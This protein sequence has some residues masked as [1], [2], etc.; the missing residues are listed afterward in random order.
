MRRYN[1]HFVDIIP[2]LPSEVINNLL[3]LGKNGVL[4][5]LFTRDVFREVFSRAFR[6]NPEFCGA[7]QRKVRDADFSLQSMAFFAISVH[8]EACY[9]SQRNAV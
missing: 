4:G 5:L 1:V 8:R 3:Q 6:E 7:M 2:Y 9:C